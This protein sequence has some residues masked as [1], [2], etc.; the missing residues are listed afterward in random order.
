MD[1]QT[2]GH[3]PEQPV[4]RLELLFLTRAYNRHELTFE[5]WLAATKA[6]AEAMVRQHGEQCYT[7]GTNESSQIDAS[8]KSSV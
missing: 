2:N 6:W 4:S 3:A 8:K 1:E 5:E 7:E